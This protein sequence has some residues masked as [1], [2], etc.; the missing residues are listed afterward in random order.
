MSENLQFESEKQFF[1]L[2]IRAR[3]I[4][5]GGFETL[6]KSMFSLVLIDAIASLDTGYVS[7]SVSLH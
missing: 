4:Y 7:E 5:K 1:I 3:G 2:E 6:K